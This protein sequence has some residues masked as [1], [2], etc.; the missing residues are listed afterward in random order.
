MY[1]WKGLL[2]DGIAMCINVTAATQL[3]TSF[4]EYTVQKN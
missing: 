1:S 4:Y 2:P 3:T